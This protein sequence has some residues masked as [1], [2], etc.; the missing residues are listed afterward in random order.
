VDPT[1]TIRPPPSEARESQCEDVV[2]SIVCLANLVFLLQVLT[3]QP[4]GLGLTSIDPAPY[5]YEEPPSTQPPPMTQ[6]YPVSQVSS[7]EFSQPVDYHLPL[8]RRH[9]SRTA[10]TPTLHHPTRTGRNLRRAQRSARAHDPIRGQR[11]NRPREGGRGRARGIPNYKPR[12]IQILLDLIEEELP[13]AAKG[14]KVVGAQFRDWAVVAE[15]PA[16]TDRSLELKYKQVNFTFAGTHDTA[17]H[18]L[19]VARENKEANRRCG[20]PTRGQ[21]STRDRPQA[22][23]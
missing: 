22:P 19:V 1:R 8:T 4:D 2:W 20:L 7:F 17:A 23:V 9:S 6:H 21:P 16:R 15:F 5:A 13:I 11:T 18:N 12:E 14:W 10:V 3:S